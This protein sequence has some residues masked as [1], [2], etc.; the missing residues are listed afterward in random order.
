MRTVG[1]V[2]AH[3]GGLPVALAENLAGD[4]RAAGGADFNELGDGWR[5]MVLAGEEV[6]GDGLQVTVGEP[7][8][9]MKRG[10]L[11]EAEAGAGT[12]IR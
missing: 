4:L 5:E 2:G 10:K 3:I 1:R 12:L 6:A 9:R 8:T 11:R 7:A